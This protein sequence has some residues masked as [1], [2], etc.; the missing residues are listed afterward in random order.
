VRK[1]AH[2]IV[3]VRKQAHR[4]VGVGRMVGATELVAVASRLESAAGAESGDWDE[5]AALLERL[6]E[7]LARIAATLPS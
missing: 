4:I 1:Q 2:R 3:G 6:H 5:L 7:L